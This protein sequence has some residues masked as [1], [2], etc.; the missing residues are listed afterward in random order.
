MMATGSGGS[1]IIT[2]V[3]QV[4]MNVIDHSMDI[5]AAV[6]APRVHISGGRPPV[7]RG[8]IAGGGGDGTAPRMR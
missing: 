5:G 1:R 7:A 8:R 3:L 2:T 4:I 6:R